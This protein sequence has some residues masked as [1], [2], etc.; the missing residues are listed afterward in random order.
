[1]GF[2]TLDIETSQWST[3]LHNLC[4]VQLGKSPDNNSLFDWNSNRFTWCLIGPDLVNIDT[5]IQH[6]YMPI[7]SSELIAGLPLV[8]TGSHMYWLCTV[9]ACVCVWIPAWVYYCMCDSVPVSVWV[10]AC[11]C[12]THI[13][14]KILETRSRLQQNTSILDGNKGENQSPCQS[15][16]TE[17]LI[18]WHSLSVFDQLPITLSLNIFFIQSP[19]CSLNP[20]IHPACR[21]CVFRKPSSLFSARTLFALQLF[22][23]SNFGCRADPKDTVFQIV[24]VPLLIAV[25]EPKLLRR[26]IP[27]C[28]R[29]SILA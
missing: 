6:D 28:G 12:C 3:H 14:V 16:L 23:H 29:E 15:A 9:C 20:D 24:P 10:C 27:G 18:T 19:V 11:I 21:L 22:P 5:F 13:D 25:I 8:C 2:W 7:I 17:F 26:F 4:N 1:M